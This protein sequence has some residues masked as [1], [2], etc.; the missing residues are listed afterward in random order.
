MASVLLVCKM[1][2]YL[3]HEGNYGDLTKRKP[4][5]HLWTWGPALS[6]CTTHVPNY[7][8]VQAFHPGT[9][10][11]HPATASSGQA[12]ALPAGLQCPPMTPFLMPTNRGKHQQ[13]A[14]QSK[15]KEPSWDKTPVHSL[16]KCWR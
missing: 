4:V 5:K 16:S 11:P 10:S 1:G 2:K 3:Q 14:R 13:C 15:G 6:V 12:E 9:W 7:H 8:Q